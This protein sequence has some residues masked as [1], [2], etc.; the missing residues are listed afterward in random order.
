MESE[1]NLAL[2]LLRMN[3]FEDKAT[4]SRMKRALMRRTL[5]GT[6]PAV[7]ETY[8]SPRAM[9][10]GVRVPASPPPK[11]PRVRPAPAGSPAG[12]P[13]GSPAGAPAAAAL[14]PHPRSALRSNQSV[15]ERLL[16]LGGGAGS[17]AARLARSQG[18]LLRCVTEMKRGTVAKVEGQRCRLW[19][20]AD[21]GEICT[22]P[23][24]GGGAAPFFSGRLSKIAVGAARRVRC[25]A[26]PTAAMWLETEADD[27]GPF[28]FGDGGGDGDGDG[29]DARD[30][31]GDDELA[32][33]LFGLVSIATALDWQ[34]QRA[35]D[36]AAAASPRPVPQMAVPVQQRL[37]WQGLRL[38][39]SEM[40]DDGGFAADELFHALRAIE[41]ALVSD[42]TPPSPGRP[43]GAASADGAS[44][45]VSSFDGGRLWGKVFVLALR[46][47]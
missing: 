45:I 15:F 4:R 28:E 43:G 13:A 30:G 24:D 40:L 19:L 12:A 7:G 37:V 27:A 20:S 9:L 5:Q 10:R 47:A 35:Q 41:L 14:P 8:R 26:R 44:K 36:R 38:G 3:M 31:G 17:L 11:P 42:A 18:V 39:L 22:Q 16:Q 32:K 46:S 29:D 2:T 25:T 1:Q 6:G 33:W 34:E 23:I 21:G